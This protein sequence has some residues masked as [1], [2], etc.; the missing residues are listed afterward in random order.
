MLIEGPHAKRLFNVGLLLSLFAITFHLFNVIISG[1][2]TALCSDHTLV[3]E[4]TIAYFHRALATCEQLYLHG[5]LIFVV[6]VLEM[7][8]AM[9]DSVV[10]PAVFC[11]V[12]ALGGV[13]LV[14]GK[15]RKVSV[16]YQNVARVK[17]LMWTLSGKVRK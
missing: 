10:Y 6:A 16:M 12:A 11:G 1:R 2:G 15:F 8:F 9:F 17:A 13:V 5:T 4:H 14:T 3:K 7:S